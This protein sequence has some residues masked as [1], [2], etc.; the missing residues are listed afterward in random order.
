MS[1][2]VFLLRFGQLLHD[3]LLVHVRI[4]N[5]NTIA[6][7]DVVCV[8]FV[9]LMSPSVEREL[10]SAGV[11]VKHLYVAAR[12]RCPLDYSRDAAFGITLPQR[13]SSH[14]AFAQ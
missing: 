2:R 9:L 4:I 10:K 7:V 3:G 5:H 11:Q 13:R 6:G 8:Q 14:D 1:V 12:V